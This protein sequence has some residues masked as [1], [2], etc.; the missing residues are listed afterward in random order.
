MT[1]ITR[2]VLEADPA[3]V[4]VGERPVQDG[5]IT[6]R[7]HSALHAHRHRA[8]TVRPDAHYGDLGTDVYDTHVNQR[9]RQSP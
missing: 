3:L 1:R 5:K 9:R 8:P 2:D 6:K 4:D 7:R